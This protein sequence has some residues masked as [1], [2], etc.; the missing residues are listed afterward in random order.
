MLAEIITIGDEILIGQIIDTNSVFISKQLNAI[1]VKVYQI[2]SIQDDEQHI[3]S[4]LKDAQSRVDLVIMTG[5]LG[6]TKDDITKQ[7]LCKFFGDTLVEN[8]DVLN[9]IK[10]VFENYVKREPLPSNLSQAMVPS[11]AIILNNSQGTAPGMWMEKDDTVFVSMPGVP[12]EMKYLISQEVLPR[13]IKK[14]N[15]PHIYHKTLLTYGKGESEIQER[16]VAWE[17]ALPSTI[18]LAY[19]PSLGRV[20]LRLSSTGTDEITVKKAVEQQMDALHELLKDIAVGYEDETNI[21]ERIA[22]LLESKNQSLSLAESC[23]GGAIAQEITAVA[24]ASAYFKGSIVPYETYQKVSVL[25]IDENLIKKHTVVSAQVAEAMALQCAK[26]FGTD[27]ALAT[28]GIAGPT[29]GDAIDELGTVHIA[30]AAPDGVFSE[31]FS[32][33][34]LRERVIK[35]ATNKAFEMLLKEILKN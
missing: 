22:A 10:Y 14:Y 15:R 3:L 29:K 9:N 13:I 6:P 19:L 30:I 33:G 1:G 32:F 4:A 24:G 16:I 34:N 7:T 2:T 18:K 27:Y 20:R 35:K 5:G 26:L 21:Q 12:Y 17:E 25:G 31:K 11:T 8:Q 28:T 23:T